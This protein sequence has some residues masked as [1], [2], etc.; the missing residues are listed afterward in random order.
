MKSCQSYCISNSK[1]W[2]RERDQNADIDINWGVG[3]VNPNSR[4][5]PKNFK[6]CQ[7]H[8]DMFRKIKIERNTMQV[9]TDRFN[10]VYL[11]T[12]NAKFQKMQ[13]S[14]KFLIECVFSLMLMRR[15]FQNPILMVRQLITNSVLLLT[16][17]YSSHSV[18]QDVTSSYQT[19]VSSFDR[20]LFA[21]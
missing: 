16:L 4:G 18:N 13:K 7:C 15:I 9:F 11:S 20:G 17:I 19:A 14:P 12:K 1:F 21:K 6:V 3:Q 2:T 8:V 10:D 5:D